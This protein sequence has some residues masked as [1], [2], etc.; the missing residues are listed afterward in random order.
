MGDARVVAVPAMN[1]A[2]GAAQVPRHARAPPAPMIARGHHRGFPGVPPG[3]QHIRRCDAQRS[4]LRRARPPAPAQRPSS[5]FDRRRPIEG[6]TIDASPLYEGRASFFEVRDDGAS[7]VSSAALCGTSCRVR[8]D[9]R[10]ESYV[11]RAVVIVRYT[12][13]SRCWKTGTRPAG[14]QPAACRRHTLELGEPDASPGRRCAR[15][16]LPGA[17]RCDHRRHDVRGAQ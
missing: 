13:A 3:G 1:V 14:R 9:G 6:D 11:A 4:I 15:H 16:P 10:L 12:T 7:S 2:F 8:G 5:S 17:K